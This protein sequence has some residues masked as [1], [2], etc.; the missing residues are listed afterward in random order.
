MFWLR[1]LHSATGMT[2]REKSRVAAS[3]G[4]ERVYGKA[5]EAAASGMRHVPG[6]SSDRTSIPNI[7]QVEDQRCM[8]SDRGM[9]A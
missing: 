5:V 8:D 3:F 6:T 7:D 1:W 4:F 2:E 9:Q